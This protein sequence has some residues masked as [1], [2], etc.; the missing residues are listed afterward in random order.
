MRIYP[1]FNVFCVFLLAACATKYEGPKPDFS[2]KGD[3][4]E[5]EISK[6]TISDNYWDQYGEAYVMGEEQRILYTD[7]SLRPII[8][9]VSP[10]AMEKLATADTLNW[11]GFGL[12]A[13][14][15]VVLF[16]ELSDGDS[17]MSKSQ[18]T[19]FWG[20]LG[21]SVIMGWIRFRYVQLG[22]RHYN[23]DLRQKFAPVLSLQQDF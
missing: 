4:A 20:L 21:S 22:A 19:A 18:E 3:R 10:A 17:S 23:R 12:W 14:S 5:K 13:A 16:S 11:V 2:L 6:F 7:E 8:N 9:E 15:T 1:F